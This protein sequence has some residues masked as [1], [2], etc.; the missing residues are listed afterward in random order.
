MPSPL[1]SRIKQAAR[2]DGA[3]T[4]ALTCAGWALNYARGFPIADRASERTFD[5]GGESVPYLRHRYNRT[6]LNERAVEVPLALRTIDRHG[7]ATLEVGNVL[8]HYGARGH[9]V[10]DRYERAPGVINEDIADYDADGRKFDLIVSISTL[11]HVG[12][13]EQPTEPDKPLR[14]IA[15]LSGL[16]APG[17]LLWATLPVGYNPTLDEHVRSGRMPFTR[18]RALQRVGTGMSW[19]EANPAA[20]LDVPYDHLLCAASAVLICELDREPSAA[21]ERR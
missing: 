12:F 21:P 18:M 5:L 3:L 17:G 7:G 10:V 16:L 2:E 15:A 19:A 13:D 1:P 6:W 11:E 4:T 14:A 8:G 9:T 20:V